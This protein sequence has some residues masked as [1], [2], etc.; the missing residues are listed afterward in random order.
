ML[1]DSIV[2]KLIK[3]GFWNQ[4]QLLCLLLF[5]H[6]AF[7]AE[8]WVLTTS[9]NRKEMIRGDMVDSSLL[10]FEL[11]IETEL[12]K[13]IWRN[14]IYTIDYQKC[15]QDLGLNCSAWKVFGYK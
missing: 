14:L 13:R 1:T 2:N 5:A 7:R 11:G 10:L 3:A 8:A 4:Q 12:R 9:N 6:A 15:S